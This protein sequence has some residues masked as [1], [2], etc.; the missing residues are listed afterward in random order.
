[1]LVLSRKEKEAVH[2]FGPVKVTVVSVR[3]NKVKLGF[4]AADGVQIQRE[5]ILDPPA[6]QER[7]V[8]A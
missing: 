1:M 6:S 7:T 4:E 5:E 8:P 2:V 3:G